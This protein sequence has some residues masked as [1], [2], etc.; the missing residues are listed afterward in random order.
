MGEFE[1]I[2]D[3]RAAFSG[4]GDTT[5][6]G[7]GDDCAIIPIGGGEAI[8]TTTDMLIEGIHFLRDAITPEQLGHKSLAVNL[9]DVAAM[10]V[11]PT[12]TLLSI[13]LPADCTEEWRERFMD[14]YRALSERFGVA[15]IGGDTTA[16]TSGIAINV[17]A[18]GRGPVTNLKRRSTAQAGDII[19]V[20]GPLGNSAEGLRNILDGNSSTPAAHNHLCPTPRVNEGAWLGTRPEVHAMMDLSDGLASDLRHILHESSLSATIESTAIPAPYGVERAVCGGEDYELLLTVGHEQ[21]DTLRHA[22]R[23]LFDAELTPV[24]KIT[25]ATTGDI[26]WLESGTQITPSWRGFTHF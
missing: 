19:A 3:I 9:S 11:R 24:G 10:G 1:F 4:I 15:L 23:E 5:I 13:A 7:I 12:A 17:T 21:F 22:Y 18:I 8:V 25:D 16:S 26:T 14:G 20:S 2:A 6:E